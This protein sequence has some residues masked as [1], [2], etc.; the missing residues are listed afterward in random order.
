[1]ILETEAVPDKYVATTPITFLFTSSERPVPR[2][3]LSTAATFRNHLIEIGSRLSLPAMDLKRRHGADLRQGCQP[4]SLK[5]CQPPANSPIARLDDRRDAC[6]ATITRR[7]GKVV[8]I[9]LVPRTAR[10]TGLAICERTGRAGVPGCGRP[11]AVRPARRRADGPQGRPPRAGIAKTITPRTLRH[12]FITAASWTLG[13]RC[14]TC[15]KPPLMQIRAPRC[16]ITGPA[17][18]WTGTP[19]TSSP[20]ASRAPPGSG[21]PARTAPPGSADRRAK[22][23]SRCGGHTRRPRT[24][25][26]RRFWSATQLSG[27]AVCLL[28]NWLLWRWVARVS[29][30]VLACLPVW[31]CRPGWR[32]RG[33]RRRPANRA[34]CQR[35]PVRHRHRFAPS[36]RTFDPVSSVRHGKPGD[37]QRRFVRQAGGPGLADQLG[38]QACP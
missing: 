20:P 14:A 28:P 3:G 16:G 21:I 30:E 23:P 27:T 9:S 8:T 19:P 2:S 17:A 35:S 36:S 7:G 1:M 31:A 29:G 5:G 18:A 32:R 11:A 22:P 12:V 13:S 15:N 37:C 38:G 24:N 6:S 10:A 33:C 25:A 26:N 4:A 34:Y